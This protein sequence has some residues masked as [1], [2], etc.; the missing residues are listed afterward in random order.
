MRCFHEKFFYKKK[1][2]SF[3]HTVDYYQHTEGHC[4][5]ISEI[6]PLVIFEKFREITFIQF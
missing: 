5:K 4:V 1:Y 2:L 6:Y 3:F